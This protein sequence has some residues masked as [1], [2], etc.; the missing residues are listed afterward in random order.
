MILA[1]DTSQ[2]TYSIALSDGTFHDWSDTKVSLYDVL[3]NIDLSEV[4][5]ITVCIGPGRFS[6][7]RSGI[8]FCLGLAKARLLPIYP[9]SSF[10]VY[11]SVITE[12]NI[13]IA[14]DARKNQAYLQTYN[15]NKPSGDITLTSYENLK[16]I[17][18]LYGNLPPSKIIQVNATHLLKACL[19][20]IENGCKPTPPENIKAIYIRPSVS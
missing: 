13:N 20:A 10:D 7:I 2:M 1:I 5:A 4:T 8:A 3:D 14:L 11:A 9:L 18:H 19:E 12:P 6:G 17:A 15:E 16:D